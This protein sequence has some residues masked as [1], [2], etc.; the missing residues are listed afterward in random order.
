MNDAMGLCWAAYQGDLNEIR[1]LVA[2][3]VDLN[4]K[5]YDGRTCL[6][7]AA[8]EGRMDVVKFLLAKNVYLTPN[9]RWQH[10]P[11]DEAKRSGHTEMVSLLQNQIDLSVS[12]DKQV[13]A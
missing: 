9:D 10:T 3:G 12:H 6:H 11:I 7:L 1:R 4:E 5:D 8:A 13:N 2:R